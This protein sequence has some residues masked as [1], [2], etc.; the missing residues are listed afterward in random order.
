MVEEGIFNIS[1]MIS[2]SQKEAEWG[3]PGEQQGH[4]KSIINQRLRDHFQI[5]LVNFLF[6]FLFFY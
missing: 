5:N 2:Q 6:L 3:V 4:V 1:G